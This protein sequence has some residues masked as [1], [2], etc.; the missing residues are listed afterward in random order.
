MN[1]AVRSLEKLDEHL[2]R[3]KASLRVLCN[4]FDTSGDGLLSHDELKAAFG[5]EG[6]ALLTVHE[7]GG[8]IGFL[9]SGHDGEIDL[10]E[11]EAAVR[12][13]RRKKAAGELESWHGASE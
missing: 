13:F 11:I 9:D 5:S 2:K 1:T 7:I 12:S 4:K 8:L 10:G 6:L 3:T